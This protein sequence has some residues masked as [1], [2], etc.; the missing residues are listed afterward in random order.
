VLKLEFPNK[1]LP[2][3]AIAT[4]ILSIYLAFISNSW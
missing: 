1:T 3:Q 4:T 2:K